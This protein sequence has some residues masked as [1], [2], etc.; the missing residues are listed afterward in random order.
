MHVKDVERTYLDSFSARTGIVLAYPF[1][2][3]YIPVPRT[4]L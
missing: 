1:R 4:T 2:Y 3:F